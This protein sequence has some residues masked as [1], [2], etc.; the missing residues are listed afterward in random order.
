MTLNI[1]IAVAT[2]AVVVIGAVS[3][4]VVASSRVLGEGDNS[5]VASTNAADAIVQ[6]KQIRFPDALASLR[7]IVR[8]DSLW[9][10]IGGANMDPQ[11]TR[12]KQSVLA[13][14]SGTPTAFVDVG[15]SMSGGGD[16]YATTQAHA[17][18]EALRDSWA[19]GD[20]P[21]GLFMEMGTCPVS[22]AEAEVLEVLLPQDQRWDVVLLTA[23]ECIDGNGSEGGA[24]ISSSTGEAFVV[25]S[26]MWGP[27]AYAVRRDYI[28]VFIDT[29]ESELSISM[30]ELRLR[31]TPPSQST[32]DSVATFTMKS[33]WKHL[34]HQCRWLQVTT[35]VLRKG[36]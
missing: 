26:G 10:G 14:V 18:L 2:L 31:P 34:Q 33:V 7:C 32:I 12:Y 4:W 28:P 11:I 36:K 13:M 3:I 19:R 17:H 30:R 1:R 6:F 29:M 25:A 8:R 9:H 23:T 21:F 5:I 27:W 20:A 35:P 22:S 15:A 24:T 16:G